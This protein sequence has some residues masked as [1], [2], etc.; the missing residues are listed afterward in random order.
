LISFNSKEKIKEL[1]QPVWG[2]LLYEDADLPNNQQITKNFVHSHDP[3]STK[4]Q[5]EYTLLC[6]ST[7]D[8]GFD[9]QAQREKK[10]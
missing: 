8:S 9:N 7:D 1:L 2:T 5:K 6:S 4:I 10:D 3:K